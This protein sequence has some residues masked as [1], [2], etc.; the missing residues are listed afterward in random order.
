MNSIEDNARHSALALIQ[1]EPLRMGKIKKIIGMA[2]DAYNVYKTTIMLTSICASLLVGILVIGP[3]VTSEA[4]EWFVQQTKNNPLLYEFVD[5]QDMLSKKIIASTV[6]FFVIWTC[7]LF[8]YISN[9]EK[10]NEINQASKYLSIFTG[11]TGFIIIV[12]G[13]CLFGTFG[14]SLF[15]FGYSL[16]LLLSLFFSSLIIGMGFFIRAMMRP[17]LKENIY[18]TKSAP[19]LFSTC[20]LLG[21]AAYLYSIFADPIQ[22]ILSINKAYISTK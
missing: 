4:Y 3:F 1:P 7:V 5:V 22:L 8:A 2:V 10:I 18:L 15:H 12:F 16:E 20:I 6:P 17:H 9:K 21:L 14:Y 11:G 13:F 19:A